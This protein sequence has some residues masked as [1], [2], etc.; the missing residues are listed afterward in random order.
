[1]AR[2]LANPTRA[3]VLD[4]LLSD[5]TLTVT[6]L[7]GEI[8]AARSTVS[9]AVGALATAGLVKRRRQG[10]TTVVSLAGEAVADALEALGRLAEPPAPVGLRQVTRMEAMRHARTCYD[11]L[12]GELGVRLADRLS[13]RG[14]LREDACGSWLLPDEGRE[15]LVELGLDPALLQTGRRQLLGACPDWTEDRPHLAGRL[16]AAICTLWLDSGLVRRLPNS[17]AVQVTPAGQAWLARL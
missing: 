3:G 8:G 2:T 11:H 15:R 10:R 4:A 12:A 16:G 1:M 7:A 13:T 6:A 5:R 14:V 9:E 17:R